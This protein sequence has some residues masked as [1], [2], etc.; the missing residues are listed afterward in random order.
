MFPVSGNP[1]LPKAAT[2]ILKQQWLL[3]SMPYMESKKWGVSGWF[4]LFDAVNWLSSQ[5][6]I[7][8]SERHL[9]PPNP[10]HVPI[11]E[12]ATLALGPRTIQTAGDSH[13]QE[14][15][16]SSGGKKMKHSLM[17]CLNTTLSLRALHC[18]THCDKN[19]NQSSVTA[20]QSKCHMKLFF[21]QIR[22]SGRWL[23]VL[24]V[25]RCAQSGEGDPCFLF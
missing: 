20:T 5:R 22:S 18:L 23:G 1:L 3:E 12:Q 2:F 21:I 17:H 8:E 9:H 19:Q 7:Y 10:H 15:G 13:L 6:L 11:T 14:E 24:G 25:A 16:S 4:S